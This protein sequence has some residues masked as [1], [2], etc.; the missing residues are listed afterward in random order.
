M[1]QV[2]ERMEAEGRSQAWL[3]RQLGMSR[4]LLYAHR[5]G[6]VAWKPEH[7]E[8]AYDLLG[9]DDDAGDTARADDE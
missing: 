2:F 8:R 7:V 3:A 6:R 9:I 1:D 4:Q 5:I